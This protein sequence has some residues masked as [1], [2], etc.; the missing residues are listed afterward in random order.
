MDSTPVTI[1]DIHTQVSVPG[2]PSV[3]TENACI[4]SALGMCLTYVYARLSSR[5][6]C[7]ANN[8]NSGNALTVALTKYGDTGYFLLWEWSASESTYAFELFHFPIFRSPSPFSLLSL[9]SPS[10]FSLSYL[11]PSVSSPSLPFLT[12][13]GNYAKMFSMFGWQCVC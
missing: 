9:F 4:Q 7:V 13:S 6:T 2:W 3:H 10:P 11:S 12:V 1:C 5:A 8:N